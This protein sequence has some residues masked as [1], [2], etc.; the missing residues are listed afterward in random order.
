MPT[1]L[2]FYLPPQRSSRFPPGPLPP[3]AA[4]R[5]SWGGSTNKPSLI[6]F[7]GTAPAK[8]WKSHLRK[9]ICDYRHLRAM[10]VKGNKP[11]P[12]GTLWETASAGHWGAGARDTIVQRHLDAGCFL[13]PVEGEVLLRMS[14]VQEPSSWMLVNGLLKQDCLLFGLYTFVWS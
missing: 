13:L 5:H 12:K 14:L 10:G 6:S 11:E 1:S 7:W 4:P 8:D 3:S 9:W 2:P